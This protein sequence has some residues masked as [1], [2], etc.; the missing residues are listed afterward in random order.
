MRP[1]PTPSYDVNAIAI[2]VVNAARM[3]DSTMLDA[4]G[5][6]IVLNCSAIR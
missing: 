2:G 1:E 6:F 5:A 4:I 3:V